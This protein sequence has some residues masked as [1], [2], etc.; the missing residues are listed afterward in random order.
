MKNLVIVS[1]G[2][3]VARVS[4]DTK[5]GS[6]KATTYEA[7]AGESNR[8]NC[9]AIVIHTMEQ[10]KEAKIKDNISIYG[11]NVVVNTITRLN[12]TKKTLSAINID[13]E[14]SILTAFFEGLN[15]SE[16]EKELWEKFLA[17]NTDMPL[18]RFNSLPNKAVVDKMKKSTSGFER[19]LAK[20]IVTAWSRLPQIEMGA[21]EEDDAI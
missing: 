10:L 18:V 11:L 7:L 2:Q 15:V 21:I 4:Y 6:P 12:N 17:I 3:E 5:G 14:E 16:L 8:T 1:F 19:N 13:D 20:A 9:L